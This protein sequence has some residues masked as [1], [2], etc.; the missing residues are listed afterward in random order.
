MLKAPKST[1]KR[2]RMRTMCFGV[3]F[4][5]A[6]IGAVVGVSALLGTAPSQVANSS[7]SGAVAI[8]TGTIVLHPGGRRCESKTF[9]NRTGQISESSAS[10]PNETRLDAKGIPI[11]L[12]TV[13]TMNSISKSFH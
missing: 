4:T 3:L 1:T 5:A 7:A 8:P 13:N 2:K 6:G 11:P 10:C 9:N 12:G